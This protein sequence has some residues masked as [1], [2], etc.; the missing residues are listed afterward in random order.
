MQVHRFIPRA[1]AA[2]A[3]VFLASPALAHTGVAPMQGFV[4]GFAHPLGGLDHLLAMVA[5][6]LLAAQFGGR[7][8]WLVPAAF[9]TAMMG[10][11]GLA[12]A[13]FGLPL[14]EFAIALSVVLFGVA[15]AFRPGLSV[16]GVMALVAAF[17]I[18]HGHAHGAEMPDGA[19]GLAYAAGFGLATGLLHLAGIALG[20]GIGRAGASQAI[21]VAG[22]GVALAGIVLLAAAG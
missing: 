4:D 22:G 15:V 16:P 2:A 10:G 19:T 1:A 8:L 11:F 21:R 5:V 17:A 20:L 14:V 9:V 13:G 6:G 12:V 3:A 7:A 18:F